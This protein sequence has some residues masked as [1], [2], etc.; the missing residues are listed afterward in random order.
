MLLVL[1]LLVRGGGVVGR[2]RRLSLSHLSGSGKDKRNEKLVANSSSSFF[3]PSKDVTLSYCFYL[4]FTSSIGE[5]YALTVVHRNYLTR[6]LSS[7]SA[8]PLDEEPEEVGALSWWPP[9]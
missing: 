7:P 8:P 9:W 2:R 4:A 6:W 1:K 5:V 3:A